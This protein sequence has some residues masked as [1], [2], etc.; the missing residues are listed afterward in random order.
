MGGAS[1]T[2]DR[3]WDP[4]EVARGHGE[5]RGRAEG[6]VAASIRVPLCRCS[7]GDGAGERPVALPAHHLDRA[8]PDGR[9]GGWGRARSCLAQDG[10]ARRGTQE[11]REETLTCCAHSPFI[12]RPSMCAAV[13]AEK[14]GEGDARTEMLHVPAR[15]SSVLFTSAHLSRRACAGAPHTLGSR[16]SF[17]PHL[18]TPTLPHKHSKYNYSCLLG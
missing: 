14:R 4:G 18:R 5:L 3:N 10:R 7:Q 2:A 17:S 1:G 15:A 16:L 11:G 6:A 13:V 8:G 9:A 12:S